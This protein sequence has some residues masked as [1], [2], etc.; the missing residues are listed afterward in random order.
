MRDFLLSG[1]AALLPA[2]ERDDFARRHAVDPATCSAL[3]GLLQLFGGTMALLTN[4]LAT[5]RAIADRN[6]NHFVQLLEGRDLSSS[7]KVSYGLSGVANW[8]EWVLQPWTLVL[9]TIPIVGL[10]RLLAW[11]SD[12]GAVG[13]PIVWAGLRLA[14]FLRRRFTMLRTRQK[15]GPERPDRILANADGGLLV[16]SYRR[17]PEWNERVTIEI[18][19]GFYRLLR[20][21]ERPD[22]GWWTHAHVLGKHPETEVFRT[23]IRYRVE[24]EQCATEKWTAASEPLRR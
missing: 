18:D 2:P 22:G 14:Q 11:S 20:V 5:F 23:L 24:V 16:L 13:E 19:E 21:E 10:V 9:V 4:G 1:I 12:R 6:A 15:F 3:L 17:K 7:E 8:L